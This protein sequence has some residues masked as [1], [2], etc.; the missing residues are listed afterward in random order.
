MSNDPR[1]AQGDLTVSPP[2]PPATSAQVSHTS[3]TPRPIPAD[4]PLTLAPQA[5]TRMTIPYSPTDK[6]EIELRNNRQ[7][8]RIVSVGGYG[9]PFGKYPRLILLW[10]TEQALRQSYMYPD[11]ADPRRHYIRL[12]RSMHDFITSLGLGDSKKVRIGVINQLERLSTTVF[13]HRD[14]ATFNVDDRTVRGV[15]ITNLPSATEMSLFVDPVTGKITDDGDNAI[16]LSPEFFELLVNKAFP[17]DKSI[18]RAVSKSS[19][20][21]DLYLWLT[22]VVYSM[23]D[24]QH[25]ML[26]DWPTIMAQMATVYDPNTAKGL[27]DFRKAIRTGLAIVKQEWPELRAE[28]ATEGL[29]IFKTRPSVEPKTKKECEGKKV[30]ASAK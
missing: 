28:A 8:L 21:I 1:P 20:A 18:L 3:D 30:S 16:R 27:R 25:A 5:L 15:H 10:L 4:K 24:T 7:T 26:L 14:E 6:T 19:F 13:H 2:P 29:L 12:G 23:R 9:L 17:Y 22:Q 11:P